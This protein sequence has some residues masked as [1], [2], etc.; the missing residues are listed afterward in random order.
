METFEFQAEVRQLLQLMI[1][2]I[3]ST[4]DIFLRELISNSSDALDKLR[5]ASFR[6][7]DLEA[8]LTDLHIEI[9]ADPQQRTLTVRDNGIGMSRDE[10]V[11]LIGTIARSGT[12]ELLK[13]VQDNTDV[14]ALIGRFG[15]GF[16]STFMVADR[17]T[18]ITRK[19]GEPAGVRWESDGQGSYTIDTVDGLP[20]GTAVTLHLKPEDTQDN[21]HDY[22]SEFRIRETVKKYSDFISWPIRMS[23]KRDG[24]SGEASEVTETLNSMKALWARAPEEVKPEEYQE[25]YRHLTHD[26]RAPLE[27]VHMRGEGTFTFEA[28][29]FLPAQAPADIFM[30]GSSSGIHLYVNR[31]FIMDDCDALMPSFLRFVKGV[32]DAG[33]LSLNVSREI[34]QQDRQIKAMRRRLV[35]KVLA[36]LGEMRAKDAERFAGFWSELGRVVK[37][38]LV[39][40][41]DHRDP[42]LDIAS[43]ASTHDS[44]ST[45]TLAEYVARMPEGQEKIYYLTGSSLPVLKQSPHLEG[46]VGKGYE[47]LLLCDPIDEM[48]VERSDF[49]G[50]QLQSIAKGQ[51]DLGTQSEIENQ[52][53]FTALVAWLSEQL[54]D[55]VREVRLTSRLTESPAC[56]VG[57]EFDIT[58]M[59][60]QYLR[61]AGQ[62]FPESKRILEINPAHP[63]VGALRE[64]HA[65]GPDADLA[66]TAR[67]LLALAQ[68]AEGMQPN[69]PAAFTRAMAGRL[70]QLM[71]R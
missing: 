5:I 24:D 45:T 41:P 36:S 48:W 71:T 2:S 18:L 20:L 58:P 13:A 57:E 4:K 65:A 26:W 8:D 14:R 7:K 61:A 11:E 15:V 25:L 29:L 37:E 69:D 60:Q 52:E 54:A 51:A 59:L 19:A 22:T 70:T 56:L 31:V 49:G 38:G 23:V 34:L 55:E 1:H 33:D 66:E 28:V 27:T 16:Y 64:K 46:F 32:V 50:K 63:L 9:S 10:V 17:V 40:D 12:A 21:L 68:I 47:V 3:Y 62:G 67:L 44:D 53:V 39:T 6:D 43:F 35:R 30:R 42:I